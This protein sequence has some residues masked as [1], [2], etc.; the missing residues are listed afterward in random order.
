MGSAGNDSYTPQTMTLNYRNS[1]IVDGRAGILRITQDGKPVS[2]WSLP[3]QLSVDSPK[4]EGQAL[5]TIDYKIDPKLSDEFEQSMSEL[6]RTLK[7][8]DMVYWG[9]FQDPVDIGH[10]LE[11][12]IADTWTEHIRQHER[13]TKNVQ[14]LEDR[15][16]ALLKDGPEPIVSHYIGKSAN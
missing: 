8:E 12:R 7:S 1:T 14:I 11:I 10:Y 16:R 15:I 4:N 13:V 6:G 5:I 2:Y 9:L 3:S